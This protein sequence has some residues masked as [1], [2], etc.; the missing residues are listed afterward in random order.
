MDFAEQVKAQV[1]IVRTVREYVPLR[2]AGVRWV[3]LCPFHTEKTPSFGVTPR[4]SRYKCFG[5]GASGDVITFVQEI[6]QLTFWEA[7]K[8][9]AERNGIPIPQTRER[10]D[11]DTELRAAVFEMYEQAAQIFSG[12][13]LGSPGS[14][15]RGYLAQRGLTQ[16]AVQTFGLGYSEA[17]WDALLR[18]F[19]QRYSQAQLKA[20]GLF[21]ERENGGFYDR[22]RGRLMFPIHNESG[23]VI[24]FGGRALR[25][26]DEPKYLN[27]PETTIYKKKGVL[28]NLHRAKNAV[29]KEDR[30]VLVEG[31]MDV[32]GVFMAGVQNVVASCGTALTDVQVRTMKRHS[33]VIV[34]NFDPDTAGSDATE[35]SLQLLLA[36]GMRVRIVRLDDGL[37]PDEFI[38]KYG[39]AAYN[40]RL[41]RAA[42]YFIWLADR[43]RAKYGTGTAEARM[44]GYEEVLQPAIRRISDRLE[45]ASVATEV[46]DYLGLDRNLVLAEFSRQSRQAPKP[47]RS[48]SAPLPPPRERQLLTSLV[49]NPGLRD[50][51]LERIQASPA[52][53]H[54]AVWPILEAICAA[55]AEGPFVLDQWE[56]HLPEE[57]KSL[58]HSVIWADDS[59]VSYSVE[60][61]SEIMAWLDAE[62]L[63]VEGRNLAGRLKEAERA[64]DMAEAF[65]LMAMADEI[66]KRLRRNADA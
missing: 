10:P 40:G 13:L 8:S 11:A 63:S 51:C 66:K 31:Y 4:M 52:A 53:R 25:A 20:S 22:F 39:A 36:E 54:F 42:G 34:V 5:C 49:A 60:H 48:P 56:Q 28:Y 9:L 55:C 24:A 50:A 35:R 61:I 21:S 27:S 46:A 38:R 1:D 45:R 26:D 41:D 65:R 64:G 16:S 44:Q 19:T 3:G 12:N 43:A 6:E 23:K 59:C 33:E 37:D 17:S 7:L 18:R 29:R 15:A 57:Q 30:L 62:D 58:L 2:R 47:D 14:E 32:V